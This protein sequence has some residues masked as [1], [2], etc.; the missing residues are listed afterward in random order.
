MKTDLHVLRV[1]LTSHCQVQDLKDISL[2]EGRGVTAV[3]LRMQRR[4]D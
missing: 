2:S 1:Y 4:S 3:K